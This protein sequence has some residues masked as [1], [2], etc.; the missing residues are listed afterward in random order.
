MNAE[1]MRSIV[2]NLINGNRKDFIRQVH[3]LK[4]YEMID[5]LM[6]VRQY[7]SDDINLLEFEKKLREILKGG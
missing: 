1:K 2:K 6:Y 4:K 5:L 3:G 7:Y